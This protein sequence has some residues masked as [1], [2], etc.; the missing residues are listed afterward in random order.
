M[1]V[2]ML[3][4]LVINALWTPLTRRDWRQPTSTR[5]VGATGAATGARAVAVG[6]PRRARVMSDR[7]TQ[8]ESYYR[9][10][11][12]STRRDGDP[13]PLPML[14]NARRGPDGKLY[15]ERHYSTGE[16]AERFAV[17]VAEIESSR[18]AGVREPLV[19]MLWRVMFDTAFDLSSDSTRAAVVAAIDPRLGVPEPYEWRKA[20][21][22]WVLWRRDD[23]PALTD[24]VIA[25]MLELAGYAFVLDPSGHRVEIGPYRGERRVRKGRVK[26]QE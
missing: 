6:H 2:T 15:G 8:A 18:R 13:T 23:E 5:H 21:G 4:R 11:E 16:G 7:I 12:R 14:T 24:E 19:V 17:V 25:F 26:V 3:E 22:R 10:A 1:R 20:R 9:L